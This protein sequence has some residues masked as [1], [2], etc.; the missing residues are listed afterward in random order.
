MSF[1]G[2]PVAGMQDRDR[3]RRGDVVTILAAFALWLLPSLPLIMQHAAIIS[4]PILMLA[5][6]VLIV[7]LTMFSRTRTA[8]L[9]MYWLMAACA[10]LLL[11]FVWR[12]PHAHAGPPGTGSDRDDALNVALRAITHLRYPYR[13]KTFLGGAI[14]P[15]PGALLLASPFYLLGNSAFQNLFWPPVFCRWAYRF[16]GGTTAALWFSLIFLI[17][18]PSSLYDFITGGD[19]LVNALYVAIAMD[20]VFVSIPDARKWHLPAA[21]VFL[22]IAISSRPITRLPE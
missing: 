8:D 16:F 14:T 7:A 19:Y 9:P 3:W 22:G 13:E 2:L 15:M 4:P 1:S 12:Y 5:E 6:L 18:C 10:F 11:L 20:L 17:G 21:A